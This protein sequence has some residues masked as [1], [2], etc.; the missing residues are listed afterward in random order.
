M[1]SCVIGSYLFNILLIIWPWLVELKNRSKTETLA[2]NSWDTSPW[3]IFCNHHWELIFE[4]KWCL[5]TPEISTPP[6]I[7]VQTHIH[8]W[9][10]TKTT[11]VF[12]PAAVETSWLLNPSSVSLLSFF[13]SKLFCISINLQY[14]HAWNT[15]I[16]Y[17][18]GYAGLLVLHLLPPLNPWLIVEIKPA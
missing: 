9:H 12:L 16:S 15:W 13:L 6:E 14:I 1:K 11:P 2:V 7:A 17:K 5:G 18:N 8:V 4:N 10:G 3:I